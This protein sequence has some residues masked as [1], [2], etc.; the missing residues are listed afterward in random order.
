VFLLLGYSAQIFA[1]FAG[2][3]SIAIGVAALYGYQLP[4]NFNYPYISKSFSE[5]W[6]RWHM[7]LSSWLREYL[8]FPL[9]GNRGRSARTYRNLMIVMLL[10][11]LWHGAAWSYAVWGGVHGVAL[12]IER[13]LG[14]VFAKYEIQVRVPSAIRVLFVFFVVTFAWI[15]FRLPN[16]SHVVAYL[17]AVTSNINLR[18]QPGNIFY[19]CYFAA[20]VFIVHLYAAVRNYLSSKFSTVNRSFRLVGFALMFFMLAVSTG[21]E[22][23][24]I[25]FQF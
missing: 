13:W 2:Y 7:S 10:G 15:F 18:I 16:F 11:G 5:F 6:T 17:T 9:G 19:I 23:T 21:P 1:D 8:Y 24:F 20:P 14:D 22:A 4:V 3:S 12:V 25:Y